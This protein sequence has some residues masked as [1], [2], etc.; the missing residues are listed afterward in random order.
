MLR[1]IKQKFRRLF[2]RHRW[3]KIAFMEGT[4]PSRNIRYSIRRYECMK[5]HKISHQD[6]RHDALAGKAVS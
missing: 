5:C 3:R 4:D 1:M 6:G 2:C